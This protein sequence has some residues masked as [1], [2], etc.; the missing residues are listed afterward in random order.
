MSVYIFTGPTLAAADAH[1]ELDATYLPPAGEGDLYRA[2]LRR[3]QAIGLIDGLFQSVPAVR[4]KEILWAMSQG[5]HVFG[6]SS[7]GALRAAE[8]WAFG[9]EGVGI[10]FESYRDGRLEDDDEVAIAHGPS[11]VGFVAASE[12]MVDIRATLR[13]AEQEGI[14]PLEVG[15]ALERIAKQL[16]YPTRSYPQLLN[17]ALESGLPAAAVT[18][19]EQWLTG[20]KVRQKREDALTMLRTMRTRLNEGLKPKKVSYF[21]EHTSMWECARYETRRQRLSGATDGDAE[22]VLRE[23]RLEGAAKYRRHRLLA[24]ARELA[25]LEANRLDFQNA[26]AAASQADAPLRQ[27]REL[28]TYPR[29]KNWLADSGVSDDERARLMTE[30][31]RIEWVHARSG[32]G[33]KEH[34]IDELRLCGEYARLRARAE[35]KKRV[36]DISESKKSSFTDVGLTEETLLQ[37]YFVDVLGE[38]VPDDVAVYLTELGFE[39]ADDL[40]RT[41]VD[42][43][44]YRHHDAADRAVSS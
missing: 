13:R 16:F 22:C 44:F 35:D 18:R 37:W 5:I 32:I 36:L 12:A 2:A 40:F 23:L 8:L 27:R 4:H 26:P 21:F 39:T 11:E 24:A 43:Y 31:A 34:L 14:I 7:M 29:S 42:E 15:T 17:C 33:R 25:L 19:L 10:I 38:S 41:L 28:N 6:S 20:G 1:A 3:P 9:M 30:E